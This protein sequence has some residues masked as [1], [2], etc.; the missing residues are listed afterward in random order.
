M[1]L[2]EYKALKFGYAEEILTPKSPLQNLKQQSE[3][4]HTFNEWLESLHGGTKSRPV[5]GECTS[6]IP[7]LQQ[8]EEVA[9]ENTVEIVHDAGTGND[10]LDSDL[11][12]IDLTDIQDE[13]DFWSSY[14]ICYVIGA[15]PPIHVME[16]FIRRVWKSYNVDKVVMVSKGMFIVIFTTMDSG[17]QVLGGTYFFDSKPIMMLMVSKRF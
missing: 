12:Q 3:I 11:V 5:I 1:R 16:G 14:I 15:N 8:F 9:I 6:R 7:I 13:I 10:K 17:D 4:R 2:W